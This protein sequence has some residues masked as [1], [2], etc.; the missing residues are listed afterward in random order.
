MAIGA[1]VGSVVPGA[2]TLAGAVVGAGV[3]IAATFIVDGLED[4]IH[5]GKHSVSD[6]VEIGGANLAEGIVHTDER[7]VKDVWHT[8]SHNPVGSVLKGLF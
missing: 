4:H 7:I 8:V 1:A 2:G 6:W 5:I 3:G